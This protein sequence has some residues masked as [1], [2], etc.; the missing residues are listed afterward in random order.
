MTLLSRTCVS[1]YQY[2]IETMPASCTVSDEIPAC[3]GQ[4]DILPQ[5]SPRCAYT[6]R[7]KNHR[8]SGGW[9]AANTMCHHWKKQLCDVICLTSEILTYFSKTQKLRLWSCDE[10]SIAL[11]SCPSALWLDECLKFSNTYNVT[12]KISAQ[13]PPHNVLQ[14]H[15]SDY[16]ERNIILV[17]EARATQDR[18]SCR[19]PLNA[20]RAC[21]ILLQ[22]LGRHTRRPEV[23]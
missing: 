19:T 12:S 4:T 21:S 15:K 8:R 7:G 16:S 6:S 22:H 13:V 18:R 3:D 2:S 11:A 17:E 10:L 23:Y 9:S 14:L 5:H 1:C 20:V